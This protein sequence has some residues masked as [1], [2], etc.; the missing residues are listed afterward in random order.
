[1]PAVSGPTAPLESLPWFR[2][3][4]LGATLFLVT[5]V[6]GLIQP[7]LAP[8]LLG[9]GLDRFQ[10]NLIGGLSS[11]LA[12]A[13]QPVFGR[14]SDR[15]DA[16]RPLMFVAAI[17]AAIA[18]HAFPL[19]RG[20]LGFLALTVIGA[21]GIQYLNTT[22]GV[23]IGRLATRS[24]G[25]T[26][27]A[28]YRVWGSVGYVALT[29]LAGRLLP[30]GAAA[31]REG[32]APVF[33]YGVPA[34]LV[35]IALLTFTI[36]DRKALPSP[37]VDAPAGTGDNAH[38]NRFLL[39]FF[40]YQFALYGASANLPLYLAEVLH[41]TKRDLGTFFAAGVVCEVLVMTQ[42]GKWTDR[43]GRKPALL[44][45]FLLMPIRLL[46]YIPARGAWAATAVQALHGINFG[47]VGAVA[48]T[49]VNDLA[50]DNARGAAQSRLAA[51]GGLALA[52]GQ[53]ACGGLLRV[54][55]F[56]L[57]FAAMSAVGA[58]GA[59]LLWRGFEESHPELRTRGAAGGA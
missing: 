10:I 23:L 39:A 32:I 43:N 41:A 11:L 44:F 27:Y 17:S 2:R 30:G 40:L 4:A 56:P 22:G 45:A 15:I 1:M 7:Y 48:V 50:A 37:Q 35:G 34:V 12:V 42:V 38:L 59:L 6:Y 9:S 36:P 28:R 24:G 47:I 25:G 13:I 5:G 21:N 8:F 3:L 16:R 26:A 46:C 20:T 57:M 55:G 49:V 58:I 29:L 52:L 53:W 54:S 14:L 33:A 31:S 51:T 19:V 18:Y